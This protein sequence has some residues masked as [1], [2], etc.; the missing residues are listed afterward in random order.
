M[1]KP[2]VTAMTLCYGCSS[3]S[4]PNKE[5]GGG[6]S[7]G[8]LAVFGCY[9]VAIFSKE[10]IINVKQCVGWKEQGSNYYDALLTHFHYKTSCVR[11]M[12]V[13]VTEIIS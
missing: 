8:V 1:N 5:K 9:I 7:H 6:C 10:Q 12:I 11:E 13:T 2:K 4:M 3:G